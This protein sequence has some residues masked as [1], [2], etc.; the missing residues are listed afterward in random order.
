MTLHAPLVCDASVVLNLGQRGRLARLVE[1]LAARTRLVVTEQVAAELRVDD[2]AYSDQF[3]QAHFQIEEGLLH[4]LPEVEQASLPDG[5]DVGESSVLALCLERGW[6]PAIDEKPGRA[7]ARRLGMKPTGTIGLLHLALAEGWMTDDE[8]LDANSIRPAGW[9]C[10][11]A[12][13][14]TTRTAARRLYVSSCWCRNNRP[15]TGRTPSPGTK[16]TLD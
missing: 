10:Q 7:V 8:C 11:G 16:S 5:L 15:T 4:K 3:L 9:T 1:C 13:L 14:T 2:K 6:V 12:G